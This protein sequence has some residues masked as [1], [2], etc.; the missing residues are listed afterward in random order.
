MDRKR[1]RCGREAGEVCYCR[2]LARSH[3]TRGPGPC[4]PGCTSLCAVNTRPISEAT[5]G[6]LPPVVA[7]GTRGRRPPTCRDATWTARPVLWA[8][9]SAFQG[10]GRACLAP[11]EPVSARQREGGRRGQIKAHRSAR[12]AGIFSRAALVI[13]HQVG[14][15]ASISRHQQASASTSI[16]SSLRA[17][18]KPPCTHSAAPVLSTC[19]SDPRKGCVMPSLGRHIFL[20]IVE[21]CDLTTIQ[22]LRRVP[23]RP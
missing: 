4:C 14:A 1:L 13:P 6:R 18:V 10:E 2:N 11:I 5:R 16:I 7:R 15:S 12:M 23:V 9:L 21:R 17:S 19:S 20:W 8:A 22:T 3:A